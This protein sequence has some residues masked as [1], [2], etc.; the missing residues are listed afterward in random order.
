[1]TMAVQKDN[2]SRKNNHRPIVIILTKIRT[3]K[4]YEWGK[5]VDHTWKPFNVYAETTLPMLQ[6]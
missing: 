2:Q 3:A 6:A 4:S 5:W 1:M